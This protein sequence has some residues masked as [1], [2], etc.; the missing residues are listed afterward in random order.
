MAEFKPFR[1]LIYSES[2]PQAGVDVLSAGSDMLANCK[3]TRL[4]VTNVDV[5]H[6]D[7][8]VRVSPLAQI[9]FDC[10]YEA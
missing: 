1:L 8:I 5:S 6:D 7:P 2:T 4:V 3:R 9:W 10:K